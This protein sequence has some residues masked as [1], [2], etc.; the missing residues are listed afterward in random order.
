MHASEIIRTIESAGGALWVTGESLG[1]RIPESE[2]SLLD[3]LRICKWELVELLS[4]R[5]AMPVG[6]RDT[7]FMRRYARAH[8]RLM[9]SIRIGLAPEIMAAFHL[10]TNR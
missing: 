1:Y 2:S 3:E 5:P 7:E 9:S 10:V 6:R 4:Q 8:E